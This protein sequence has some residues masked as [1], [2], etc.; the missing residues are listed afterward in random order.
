MLDEERR[1][2][3]LA[4][5]RLVG[6]CEARGSARRMYCPTDMRVLL[7]QPTGE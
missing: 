3:R 5:T 4:G 1:N 6:W 2:A 7:V